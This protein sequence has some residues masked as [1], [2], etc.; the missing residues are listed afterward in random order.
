MLI[1]QALDATTLLSTLCLF[2][3][4]VATALVIISLG[5][6]SLAAGWRS[7]PG[8]IPPAYAMF[9]AHIAFGCF[10]PLLL[11]GMETFGP[12]DPGL[13]KVAIILG[14]VLPIVMLISVAIS[15]W[16]GTGDD[17]TVD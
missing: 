17:K 8:R 4:V 14:L 11:L 2:N 13:V 5:Q 9:M 3:I 10:Y 6:S 15:L 16:R 12:L 7:L 1:D